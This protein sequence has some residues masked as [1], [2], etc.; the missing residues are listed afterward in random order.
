MRI[1]VERRLTNLALKKTKLIVKLEKIT[2]M[3]CMD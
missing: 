3:L 1:F 2:L